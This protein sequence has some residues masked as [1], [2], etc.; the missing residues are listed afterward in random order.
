AEIAPFLKTSVVAQLPYLY[1]RLRA[2]IELNRKLI[3]AQSFNFKVCILRTA[4]I[5]PFLK[6]SVVAQLPYLHVRLRALI[7]LNRKL[8]LAQSF[9]FKV[10]HL[11]RR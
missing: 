7:E 3:L 8:K 5:A 9:N 2:L 4:E 10:C 6:T 1:V 11:R